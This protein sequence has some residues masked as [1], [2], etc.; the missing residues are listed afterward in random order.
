MNC[1]KELTAVEKATDE[2]SS[3]LGVEERGGVKGTS[4]GLI[5]GAM[6]A[7]ID[8]PTFPLSCRARALWFPVVLPDLRTASVAA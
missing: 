6:N 4:K 1:R 8:I 2:M 3:K 7:Q 5:D